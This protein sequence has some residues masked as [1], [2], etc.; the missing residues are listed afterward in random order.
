VRCEQL[1]W[2]SRAQPATIGV[3]SDRSGQAR[4]QA[5]RSHDHGHVV[6]QRHQR[7]ICHKDQPTWCGE[8]RVLRDIRPLLQRSCVPCHSQTNAVPSGALVLDD[9][10]NYAGL[11]GDYERLADDSDARWGYPPVIG[12]RTCGRPTPAVI[13]AC[14]KAGA[15]C[16]Y[17]RFLADAWTAGQCR[18]SDRKDSRRLHDASHRR[19]SKCRRSRLHRHNHAAP[20]SGVPPL[21]PDEKLTFARWIDLGCPINTGTGDDANYGWFLDELRPTLT[22]SSPRQ[23][24]NSTPLTEIRLGVADADSGINEA[25]LSVKA[26]FV[27][28]GALPG[29]ELSQQG[30]F[31]SPG[32]FSL[33]LVK[34]V[35]NLGIQHVTAR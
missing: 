19:R 24:L 21:S 5:D 31:V 7:I 27:L 6:D 4:L 28:N 14:F 30:A 13:S 15:A 2:L 23:N 26:D 29:T 35:S 32:V 33:P 20:G 12:T 22:V 18:S 8:C 3:R 25:T 10:S 1:R 17:G 34:S 9:H 11:P 16:S